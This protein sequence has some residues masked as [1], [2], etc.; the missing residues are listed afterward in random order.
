MGHV[1]APWDTCPPCRALAPFGT[2]LFFWR[3]RSA[4]SLISGFIG[5]VAVV[6]SVDPED[7]GDMSCI[8]MTFVMYT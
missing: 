3:L 1:V 6:C 7:E 8:E 2:F 4:K 5:G